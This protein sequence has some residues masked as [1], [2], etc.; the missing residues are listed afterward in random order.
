[1]GSKLSPDQLRKQFLLKEVDGVIGKELL[2]Q[3]GDS[4][5]PKDIEARLEK[6]LAIHSSNEIDSKTKE[7]L[8][9]QTLQEVFLEHKGLLDLKVDEQ[10]LLSFY[11]KNRK[12][13]IE[14]K[15]VKA[16]HILIRLPQ[17]PTAA[18]TLEA[19]QKAETALS[20][21]KKGKDFAEVARQFSDSPN[22]ENGGDLGVIKENYISKEFDAIAFTLKPGETSGIVNCKDGL[23]IIRVGEQ[24][25][26]KQMSFPEVKQFIAG[27]LQKD[28]QQRKINDLVQELKKNAAIEILIK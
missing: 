9:K 11:E 28:Y 20:E 17:K 22:K 1:M 27:Y 5:K 19:R 6:R 21:L 2:A 3:A 10:E 25:P 26:E 18:Q 15:S 12:S 14:S 7:N 13:F 8:R 23:H 16:Q 24:F 4:L